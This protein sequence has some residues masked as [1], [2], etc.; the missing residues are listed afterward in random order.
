M[1]YGRRIIESRAPRST[2]HDRK[3]ASETAFMSRVTVLLH[4]FGAARKMG[5]ESDERD[6]GFPEV[7]PGRE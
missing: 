5:E 1:L 3:V 6:V 4:H 2:N 7:E